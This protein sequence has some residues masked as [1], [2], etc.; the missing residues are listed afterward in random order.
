MYHVYT[1][2]S[3]IS[4]ELLLLHDYDIWQKSADIKHLPITFL[5]CTECSV[6][7]ECTDAAVAVTFNTQCVRPRGLLRTMSVFYHCS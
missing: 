3:S 5:F 2:S 7:V 6:N 4:Q 1:H